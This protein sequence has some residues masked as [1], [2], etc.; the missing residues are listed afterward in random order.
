M[1]SFL[2]Y[3]LQLVLSP[4][5]G[6]E[7]IAK[8]DVRV[9]VLL[10]KGLFPL[11]GLA[12][13]AS[14]CALLFNVDATLVGC[15]QAAVITFIRFFVTY[16]F[17]VL[18]FT[19]LAS[20]ILSEPANGNNEGEVYELDQKRASTFI[21]YNLG[22]LVLLALLSNL[23]PIEHSLLQFFPFLVAL[24]MWKGSDFM[25]V[26]PSRVGHFTFLSVF[27]ILLPTYLLQYFFEMLLT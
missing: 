13:A 15:I 14:F 6:W 1:L 26:V 18:I 8:A 25:G 22:V 9:D 11:T 23:I 17:A 2:K 12:S 3:M 21:I 27:A 24:L 10:S 7:D 19:S 4:H 16:Y 20:K 5:N